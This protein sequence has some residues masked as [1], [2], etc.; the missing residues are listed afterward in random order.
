MDAR[1]SPRHDPTRDQVSSAPPPPEPSETS[2]ASSG[3]DSRETPWPIRCLDWFIPEFLARQSTDAV[4]RARLTITIGALSGIAVFATLVAAT[5]RPYSLE[6]RFASQALAILLLSTPLLVRLRV[7][8]Y[9]IQNGLIA[10]MFLYAFGLSAMTGGADVAGVIVAILA[11]LF[12]VLMCGARAGVIWS[13][14]ACVALSGIAIAVQSGFDAPLHPRQA[15]VSL[16]SLWA[17]IAGIF[18]TASVALTYEWLHQS[19]LQDLADARTTAERRHAQVLKLEE[20]FRNNLEQL[21]E[22]R[23]QE[24]IE[25]REQLRRSDRL[26]SIGT[27]AAGVAHQINNP[28]G[29]ILIGSEFALL[30]TDSK[31]R[32][33]TY[34]DALDSNVRDAK[35]CGEIVRNLLRFSRI[36]IT[37]RA[38]LD[39]NVAVRRA[40]ET[41]HEPRERVALELTNHVLPIYA[42]AIEIEQVILN[43]VVNALQSGS[44]TVVVST[45]AVGGKV[46]VQVAD[47][48]EGIKDEDLERLFDP[49]FTTRITRGGTG[50][51][52]SIVHG[53][54]QEHEGTVAVESV[55]GVGTKF[56]VTLPIDDTP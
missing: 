43:I 34:R 20:Q 38:V 29:S 31:N 18:A 13:A 22:D 45:N 16:W 56:T 27:L 11:P 51:G 1:S 3:S 12:A 5:A 15:D 14:I 7:P 39:L 4:R 10:L 33:Q 53:I 26:A 24:L 46:E 32:E 25:S 40:I 17:G 2:G 8:I 23:T 55:V 42:N 36:G 48:G 44:D 47:R 30:A 28:I 21:V 49:F 41:L 6:I 54:V 52:L 50:L 35:R 19:M 9:L 37:D